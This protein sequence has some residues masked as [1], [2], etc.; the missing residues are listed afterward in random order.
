MDLGPKLVQELIGW[1][2]EYESTFSP[3]YPPDSGFPS[4]E[5]EENFVIRG[6][7][8]AARISGELGGVSVDTT[9]S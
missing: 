5:R 2:A 4:P 7:D 3:E 9:G 6:C 8:L 1:A